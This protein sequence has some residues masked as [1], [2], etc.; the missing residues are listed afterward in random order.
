MELKS[1]LLK[2]LI[3]KFKENELLRKGSAVLF[4]IIGA[5]LGYVFLLLVTRKT[6]AEGWGAFTLCLALLNLVSIISRFGIDLTYSDIL[7]NL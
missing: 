2:N 1:N 4:K 5:I 6:G 3:D 7:L